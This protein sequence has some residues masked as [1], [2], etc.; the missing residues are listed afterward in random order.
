[1]SYTIHIPFPK[2][3]VPA[4]FHSSIHGASG[5]IRSIP[6]DNSP[7]FPIPT[8]CRPI[9]AGNRRRSRTRNSASTLTPSIMS[10][11]WTMAVLW[12][13][14]FHPAIAAA[15][16]P[17]TTANLPERGVLQT[18]VL[19]TSGGEEYASYR[20][21]SILEAADGRLIAFAEG[22]KAD[23]SD[24][25][26]IDLVSRTSRDGGQTWEPIR[27]VW[28]DAENT[29]GNPCPVI[30][31]EGTIHLLLT[32]NRGDDAE[33]QIIGGTSH[34]TRRV[35]VMTSRD[36]G[37]TWS[38]PREI[39][40]TTKQTDWTW[41]A[42][43]PGAGIRLMAG[44]YTGRLVI[45]CDHVEVESK[46]MRSHVIYSDD[47]GATWQLGGTAP[48]P[49]VNE[50]EVAELPAGV[51]WPM[52]ETEKTG[53]E[54]LHTPGTT[55]VTNAEDKPNTQNTADITNIT[56]NTKTVAGTMVLNMRNYQRA[57][58]T[59]Q[60]CRSDD[61]GMTWSDQQ[62]DVAL[63]E[64]ICQ[65]SF[66]R[67]GNGESSE[68]LFSNPASETRRERI[69]IRLSMDAAR[70]WTASRVLDPRPSAYSCLVVMR[71]GSFGCLY[72]A[73]EHSPYETIVFAKFDRDWLVAAPEK[74]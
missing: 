66:R 5:R 52:G 61:G 43:G 12:V 55:N 27:V 45:P 15:S 53:K 39:T 11:G 51:D 20:I 65:A 67:V 13:A 31:S 50:C 22:R 38:K 32:W 41:Y 10:I 24:T 54:N 56:G 68:Y 60:T 14:T 4:I 63:V 19:F 42:T 59:R 7:I 28:D 36:H 37:E 70:T 57:T 3:F 58:P 62:H 34:D 25:G 29:C 1:M 64:P 21:P 47:H 44:P 30:D 6:T 35:F 69:T 17:A 8:E 33:A 46:K 74:P 40:E 73:G 9:S 26:N 23:A 2:M 71:D 48:R 49:D 72:E 16:S 18:S